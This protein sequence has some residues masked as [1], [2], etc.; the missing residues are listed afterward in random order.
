MQVSENLF[1]V[2]RA[3]LNW[4]IQMEKKSSCSTLRGSDW[5]DSLNGVA[6]PLAIY[7]QWKPDLELFS[8]DR[9]LGKKRKF[10]LDCSCDPCT[11][12]ANRQE[13]THAA[14]DVVFYWTLALTACE[15]SNVLT[16]SE[17]EVVS[18]KLRLASLSTRTDIDWHSANQ[19]LYK[20]LLSSSTHARLYGY[21]APYGYTHKL[22]RCRACTT[23][24]RV[25]W[26]TTRWRLTGW[27]SHSGSWRKPLPPRNSAK[28]PSSTC[29]SP[30]P[31]AMSVSRSRLF[32]FSEKATSMSG[33][34]AALYSCVCPGCAKIARCE[35][36]AQTVTFGLVYKNEREKKDQNWQYA[37]VLLTYIHL[38]LVKNRG[39]Q[40][41]SKICWIK[42]LLS[43]E[44]EN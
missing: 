38:K 14:K 26:T 43:L 42:V 23:S 44:L 5:T 4:L 16:F 11:V 33:K 24:S 36:L 10:T 13:L 30:T 18:L 2:W 9:R 27:A 29:R 6:A 8:H 19:K 40:P 12:S 7:P 39:P 25:C 34:Q 41:S 22:P 17:S 28:T 1:R 3:V 32:P 35:L 21:I 31:R 37:L 15:R 20:H